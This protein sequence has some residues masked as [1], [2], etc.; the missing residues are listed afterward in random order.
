M[1][2]LLSHESENLSPEDLEML[3]EEER[4]ILVIMDHITLDCD[5]RHAVDIKD[6]VREKFHHKL[7]RT[8]DNR[9]FIRN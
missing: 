1:A 4:K 5:Y 8:K 9:F 7:F 6:G 2:T 3:S